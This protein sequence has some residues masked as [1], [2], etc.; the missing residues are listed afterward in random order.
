L[1]RILEQN[2]GQTAFNKMVVCPLFP[3]S[4][5]EIMLEIINMLIECQ[6][7]GQGYVRAMRVRFTQ[8]LLWVCKECD[9]TWNRQADVNVGQ[10]E[11]YATLMATN[12]HSGLWEE[13]EPQ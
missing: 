11:D 6:R 3:P 5:P 8:I 2:S 10:F 13:L 1:R 12:G 4:L 9:A 7:R